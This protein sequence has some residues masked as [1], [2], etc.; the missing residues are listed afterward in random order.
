MLDERDARRV[1]AEG[2]VARRVHNDTARLER[3]SRTLASTAAIPGTAWSV[4]PRTNWVQV[5]ADR[6]VTGA[7][8][9]RL[10]AVTGRMA[11]SVTLSRT[12][13]AFRPFAARA[14]TRSSAAAGAA[15]S[16]ST[17]RSAAAP[18][19]S[20]RATAATSR[21]AGR[22]TRRAPGRWAPS[23]PPGSRGG[24]RARLLRRPGG[25]R[26]G[27]VGLGG[28]RAQ[29]IRR[30]ADAAV[31][32]RVTRA[33]STSGVAQATVTALD[34]TVDYGSGQVVSGLIQTDMCARTGDS[35]GPLFAGD[36]ALGITSGGSATCVG[37]ARRSSSP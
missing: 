9:A 12:P 26:P 11:S 32:M 24:L 18:A 25:G 14:A 10:T 3:I 13:G 20:P 37:A 21:R 33:G 22:R 16:G 27:T 17:S 15:R 34:A 2:V 5:T 4:D 28:G 23:S 35:G 29:P 19:S 30:A 36:T 8:L 31:G 6:T 7:R 1:R